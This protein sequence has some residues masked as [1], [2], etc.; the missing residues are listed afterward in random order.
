MNE[1]MPIS[2]AMSD[3]VGVFKF[4]HVPL[5]PMNILVTIHQYFSR[6]LGAFSI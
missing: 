4:K 2:T 3:S 6:I 1:A 5:G